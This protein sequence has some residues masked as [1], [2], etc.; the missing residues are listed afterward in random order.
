MLLD[1]AKES[2]KKSITNAI[3]FS[4]V[5]TAS[6]LNAKC[7]ITPTATGVTARVVSKFKPKALIVGVTPSEE[8]LRRMQIYRGV[9]PIKSI[10]YH[11]TDEVCDEAI[12]LANAKGL[13]ESGDIVVVTAGIP[14]SSAKKTRD[15]MSNMMRIAI[16]D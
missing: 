9:Y 10:P 16:V 11:T 7:I 1:K 14:T 4:S 6:S 2:R 3:G 5:A 13:V 15:A 8:T 12:N